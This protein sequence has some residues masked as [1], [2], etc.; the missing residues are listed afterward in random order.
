MI[1]RSCCGIFACMVDRISP[2]AAI[3]G[4]NA[5]NRSHDD[6]RVATAT[7]LASALS[8]GIPSGAPLCEIAATVAGHLQSA[9]GPSTRLASASLER[10]TLDFAREVKA[11]TIGRPDL[12]TDQ[13]AQLIG[14]AIG[15]AADHASALPDTFNPTDRAIALFDRAASHLSGSQN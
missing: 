11:L 5:A 6:A 4:V 12:D 13:R 2:D 9:L 3:Q 10:A 15:E 14:E 8:S 1:G 7:E